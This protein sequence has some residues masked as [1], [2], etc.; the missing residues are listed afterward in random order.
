M[1]L[2]G[3]IRRRVVA[4]QF[5][6]HMPRV[7][8]IEPNV[9]KGSLLRTTLNRRV[10]G[11]LVVDSNASA[12]ESLGQNVPE[13]VLLS[14]RLSS[15]DEDEL[16]ECLRSLPDSTHIQTLT[17]PQIRATT[18][19]KRR[20]KLA[21]FGSRRN[22]RD[23][24]GC[25]PEVFA[26]Q[27]RKYLDRA[28]NLKSYAPPAS[29]SAVPSEDAQEPD[30]PAAVQEVTVEETLPKEA[31][32]DA[33]TDPDVAA[34]TE[35]VQPDKTD[36]AAAADLNSTDQLEVA[37]AKVDDEHTAAIAKL[38]LEA[39]T[40]RDED[41]RRAR[42]DAV[43]DD[44]EA[45]SR[46]RGEAERQASEE[47]AAAHMEAE[48][49]QHVELVRM[50]KETER[51]YSV[52]LERAR[53]EAAALHAE[54]TTK[55]QAASERLRTAAAEEDRIAAEAQAR[56]LEV[57]LAR[58]RVETEERLAQEI[59]RVRSEAEKARAEELAAVEAQAE[60]QQEAAEAQSKQAL[61]EEL[62]QLRRESD[63]RLATEL[64]LA[65]QEAEEAHAAL[66]VEA[67]GRAKQI[68]EETRSE[69]FADAEKEA[70]LARL[71]A[72]NEKRRSTIVHEQVIRLAPPSTEPSLAPSMANSDRRQ[73]PDT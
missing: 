2:A 24:G 17:I 37:R 35:L 12:L 8:A 9:E 42:E 49:R 47:L 21:L 62:E 19:L 16:F 57:E 72:D 40:R 59:E 68:R 52:E 61:E 41:V 5:G 39:E 18:D 53:F 60:K 65:R 7:L 51:A 66:L 10:E 28:Q 48:N 50:R 15:G 69:V 64:A 44:A 31:P 1:S 58:G 71:K 45:L 54:E 34:E 55:A 63:E 73:P 46:V 14:A 32:V 4:S 13:L 36:A 20:S 6:T 23:P 67:D 26:Q 30:G 38:H 3:V 56:E 27:V 11:V 33:A 29:G 70:E 22:E 25:E 43:T